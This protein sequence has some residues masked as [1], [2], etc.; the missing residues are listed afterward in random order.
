MKIEQLNREILEKLLE[1]VKLKIV[2]LD[3]IEE[4]LK[5][6][7]SIAEVAATQPLMAMELEQLIAEVH[8]L[9]LEVRLLDMDLTK[10]S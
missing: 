8:Q 4:K 7:R 2:L 3:T 10:R 6:I 5:Q 9:E 1:E